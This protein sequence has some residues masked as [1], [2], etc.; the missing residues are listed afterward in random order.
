[1]AR[2]HIGIGGSGIGNAYPLSQSVHMTLIRE[3]QADEALNGGYGMLFAPAVILPD[4]TISE[5]LAAAPGFVHADSGWG[6]VSAQPCV[7]EDMPDTNSTKSAGTKP[8]PAGTANSHS[9]PSAAR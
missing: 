5:R 4:Q 6:I 2:I 7:A 9:R 3:G 1:M 8:L